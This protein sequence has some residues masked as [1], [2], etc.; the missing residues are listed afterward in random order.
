MEGLEWKSI[1]DA[2]CNYTGFE[3][4]SKNAYN[5]D[6][7][8]KEGYYKTAILIQEKSANVPK[9]GAYFHAVATVYKEDGTTEDYNA[10]SLPVDASKY[11]TV[12]A[13]IYIAKYG[14]HPMN[15]GTN[16]YPALNVYTLNG[17]RQ[18]PDVGGDNP[19]TGVS[20]VEGVNIHKT[21]K[22]DFIG[23]GSNGNATSQ[24]C[25]NIERGFED[26]NW[27]DFLSNFS[28]Q[29]GDIGVI[30][31]RTPLK[32]KV[33]TEIL[34][35]IQKPQLGSS[36]ISWEL[37]Y[38]KRAIAYHQLAILSY[39]NKELSVGKFYS[40]MGKLENNLA[41]TYQQFRK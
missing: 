21:G 4:D 22:D 24:G 25:I 29:G 27:N 35:S 15:G 18:L 9:D 10:T 13:G 34:T 12:A 2:N 32:P 40:R 17:S 36:N 11:G 1:K 37:Y 5:A 19:A 14:Q 38:R 23:I 6:K 33:S 3:W 39:K 16:P 30:I 20:Y 41:N 8:L 31:N 28:N 7:S 26:A